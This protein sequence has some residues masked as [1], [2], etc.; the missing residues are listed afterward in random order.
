MALSPPLKG[1]DWDYGLGNMSNLEPDTWKQI[2]KTYCNIPEPRRGWGPKGCVCACACACVF[3]YAHMHMCAARL[4][5]A[6]S[7]LSSLLGPLRQVS[8]TLD[9]G[10]KSFKHP[11]YRPA[12]GQPLMMFNALSSHQILRSLFTNCFFYH[13]HWTVAFLLATWTNSLSFLFTDHKSF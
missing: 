9:K 6:L 4:G 12:P 10:H 3:V 7:F 11:H 13:P 2:L 5:S 1:R 8:V